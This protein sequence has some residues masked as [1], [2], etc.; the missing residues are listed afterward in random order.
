MGQSHDGLVHGL[1]RRRPR[2]TPRARIAHRSNALALH[3]SRRQG[4]RR[5]EH[6]ERA[7]AIANA[8][9]DALG[10]DDVELPLT[11]P[12]VWELLRLERVKPPPFDYARPETLEEALAELERGGEDAKPLAGGQSLVPLLNMRLARPSRARRPQPRRA[13]TRSR[14]NGALRRRRDGA[15]ARDAETCRSSREALPHVGHVV[16]RNSGTVG[17]SI[18]HADPAAE[19]PCASSRSAA[20]SWSR[21]PAGAA[22]SP[23]SEFFLAPFTTALEP[24]ELVV[25][26]RLAAARPGRLRVRGARAA[27]RRLRAVDGARAA[28]VDGAT[29]A[30]RSRSA[31]W[32]TAAGWSVD[33][34]PAPATRPRREAAAAARL[35]DPRHERVPPPRDAGARRARRP[36]GRSRG[37]RDRD[38]AHRERAASSA[39]PSSRGC[40]SR[41]SCAIRSA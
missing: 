30:R 2:P 8:V 38:R 31:P 22:R 32:S 13:S 25:E 41:T 12:R 28:R 1:P 40:C 37:R 11:A 7:G 23:P 34:P 39:R 26:T 3:G 29:C 21:A 5:G 17:G 33:C 15:P 16:T 19:L 20:R 4:P 27:A 36:S 9:A 35:V 6:D 18:A 14:A 10:R 24:G